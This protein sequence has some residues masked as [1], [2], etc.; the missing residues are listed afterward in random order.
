MKSLSLACEWIHAYSIIETIWHAQGDF[1]KLINNKCRYHLNICGSRTFPII[2]NL[3][4]Y[5]WSTCALEFFFRVFLRCTLTCAWC[6]LNDRPMYRLF[7]GN[8]L[9]HRAMTAVYASQRS[10]RTQHLDTCVSIDCRCRRAHGGRWAW[11]SSPE[12]ASI[13]WYAFLGWRFHSFCIYWA[14]YNKAVLNYREWYI[15]ISFEIERSRFKFSSKIGKSRNPIFLVH[16]G[17]FITMIHLNI[18][19]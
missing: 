11:A 12:I 1:Q 3:F 16:R 10:P 9:S 7:R 2:G 13:F 18:Q 19:N 4:A 14:T 8:H 15:P 17:S 5:W 6:C